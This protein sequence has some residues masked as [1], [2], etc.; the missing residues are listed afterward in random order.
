MASATNRHRS[1][2]ALALCLGAMGCAVFFAIARRC[3]DNGAVGAAQPDSLIFFQYARAM[4]EG[5]PYQFTPGERPST[6]S[7]SHL[8]PALLSLLCRAGARGEALI[9]AGFAFNAACYLAFLALL[10]VVAARLDPGAAPLA[11]VLAA[12]HGPILYTALGQTDMGL[13]MAL[14]MGALA[15]AAHA[16]YLLLA[17]ALAACAWCR[18]EGAVLSAAMMGCALFRLGNDDRRRLAPFLAGAVGLACFIMVLGLN[19]ALTGTAVFQRFIGRGLWQVC[20]PSGALFHAAGSLGA[21][22]RQI[23]FGIADG[24]PQFYWLPVAGGLLGLFGLVTRDWKSGRTARA[25]AWWVVS[26]AAAGVLMALSGWEGAKDDRCLAWLLPVWLIYIAVG[27]R[28]AAARFAWT[29][30]YAVFGLALLAYQ[31]VGLAYF[32]SLFAQNG[33]RMA[34]QARFCREVAEM[35]SSGPR[36]GVNG[37]SG[38]AYFM[39]NRSVAD[40]NGVVSPAFANGPFVVCNAELLKR[41]P[42][43]R[44][45]QW[46]LMAPDAA[47]QWFSVFVGEEMAAETPAFG[48]D[49]ALVLRRARWE[50]L[51]EAEAPC[52]PQSVQALRGMNRIDSLDVGCLEDE[53]RCAYSIYTR[54]GGARLQPFLATGLC[55]GRTIAEVGQAVLGAETFRVRAVPAKTLRVVL[56]TASQAS[57]PIYDPCRTTRLQDFHFSSPL[58]LRLLANG[59]PAGE[60]QIELP[61]APGEF[62]EAVFDVPGPCVTT[63]PAELTVEG[64]HIAFAYWFYQ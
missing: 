57:V 53:A 54:I 27:A 9:G 60:T 38:L 2:P 46:L 10:W 11:V 47:S 51:D 45:D 13:F 19:T 17:I 32:A 23:G 4:A 8:Y 58:A 18:P 36:I 40:V 26:A 30:A 39:P 50:A 41:D 62:F 33:A 20:P 5:R 42:S 31:A 59:Q 48:A 29:P 35:P 56:R 12:T 64:D 21:M 16:R 1:A 24:G 52:L 22:V 6:G 3:G 49:Q 15:A 37:M 63:D 55:G 44:F 25:E 34:S 14:S 7:P 61:Q 28:A 43:L